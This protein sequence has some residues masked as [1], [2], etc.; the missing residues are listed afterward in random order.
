MHF[1]Y[2]FGETEISNIL[3]NYSTWMKYHVDLYTQ[4]NKFNFDV[5][6]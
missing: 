4:W 1:A 3:I 6:M 2:Y 5:T